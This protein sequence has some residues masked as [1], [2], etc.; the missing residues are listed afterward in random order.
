MNF[1]KIVNEDHLKYLIK[2]KPNQLIACYIASNENEEATDVLM[3][4][5]EMSKNYRNVIFLFIDIDDYLI[6]KN[7]IIINRI[8]CFTL[9]YHQK[10]ILTVTD[11]TLENINKYFQYAISKVMNGPAIELK[12]Y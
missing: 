3:Y 9:F 7:E 8:P 6:T 2:T 5:K 4:L 1:Y 11:A 10:V 12:L